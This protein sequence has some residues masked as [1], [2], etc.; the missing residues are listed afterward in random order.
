MIVTIDEFE[1]SLKSC[2]EEIEEEQHKPKTK[3]FDSW[4]RAIAYY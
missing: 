4:L 1:R 2:E 3:L